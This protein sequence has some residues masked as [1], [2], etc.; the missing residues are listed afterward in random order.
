[1]TEK[2]SLDRKLSK[3]MIS[4]TAELTKYDFRA[5]MLPRL[6]PELGSVEDKFT[7]IL[8]MKEIEMENV[9]FYRCLK[10]MV[11]HCYH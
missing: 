9:V 10:K 4:A 8:P 7:Q 3:V 11:P 6:D 1:M 2:L 5:A